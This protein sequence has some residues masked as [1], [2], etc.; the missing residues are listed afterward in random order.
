M[1]IG[2]LINAEPKS[3]GKGRFLL[4]PLS[5]PPAS[6]TT[7]PYR[8]ILRDIFANHHLAD[9]EAYGK[10]CAMVTK[11]MLG[12]SP[13]DAAVLKLT[14]GDAVCI[15]SGDGVATGTVT[16]KA[17]IRQGVLECMLFLRKRRE[18]LSLSPKPAKVIDVSVRKA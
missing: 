2:D 10:G 1:K 13:E 9:R 6:A 7:R 8:L 3:I 14:D 15:E 18:M 17:G 5:A 4:T 12:V 11:D 16:I